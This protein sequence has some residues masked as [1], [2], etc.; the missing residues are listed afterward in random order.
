MAS[1]TPMVGDDSDRRG[2]V[3]DLA[4]SVCDRSF[5]LYGR[6]TDITHLLVVT[7]GPDRLAPSLA[8]ELRRKVNI[9]DCLTIDIVQGCSG[10][11]AA[12]ILAGQLAS[13]SGARIMVVA[14]DAAHESVSPRSPM[15][16]VLRNGAFCC[17]VSHVQNDDSVGLLSHMTRQY[18]DLT[19]I[20]EIPI[21]H[22]LKHLVEKEPGPRDEFLN[23]AAKFGF[24]VDNRMV[25]KML[26]RSSQLMLDLQELGVAPDVVVSHHP[27]ARISEILRGRR[28]FSKT[29]FVDASEQGNCGAAT[30]GIALCKAGDLLLGKKVLV[31]GF[32]TGGA[33]ACG[34]WQF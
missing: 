15:R 28:F 5:T 9:P 26:R 7:S 8:Q 1:Y 21:G 16:A 12:L 34:I 10:G 19:D 13:R 4:V 29:V 25:L 33:F 14:A 17:M 23:P 32:G 2:I 6:P 18:P 3:L 31:G 22:E 30:T 27:N 11:A 20:V 24:R